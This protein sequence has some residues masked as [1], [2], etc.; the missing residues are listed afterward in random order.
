MAPVL[1]L[2]SVVASWLIFWGERGR[3]Q[4]RRFG[5]GHTLECTEW[6]SSWPHWGLRG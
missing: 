1:M 2:Y 5:A 6:S 4:R 3:G